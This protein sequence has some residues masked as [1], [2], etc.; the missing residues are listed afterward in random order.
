MFLLTII[1]SHNND[2]SKDPI[3]LIMFMRMSKSC[4]FN[5]CLISQNLIAIFESN[6]I[7][8]MTIRMHGIF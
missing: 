7:R 4:E 3:Y 5:F 8:G 1:L 6:D 2:N